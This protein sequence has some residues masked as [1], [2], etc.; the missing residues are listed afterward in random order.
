MPSTTP[1]D[2]PALRG[3][4]LRLAYHGTVVVE[5]AGLRLL[6]GEVTALIGPNGSGKSTVLRALA[7]LHKPEAGTVALPDVPDT[8]TLSASE[9]ARRVTLLSQSRPTPSGVCVRDV[10]GYGRH[11]HRGRWRQSDPD[12]PR[13]IAWAMDVTGTTAMAERPV[14]ELS[15]GELQRVWLA[16][17][18]AQDTRVLLLDEPTT[19]LD[20]RYQVE[21]LD[22][23][24]DLADDHGVAVGV[25][26]HDLDQA[27][28]VADHVVLLRRGEVVGAGLP[29]EVL[30]ADAL[31]ETYGI[32]IDVTVDEHGRVHTRPV[33]RHTRRTRTLAAV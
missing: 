23:V 5:R 14:D 8:R 19:Y 20:L 22:L 9:F 30:T 25:V 17:C 13:A 21:I 28:A 16:T 32:R 3:E 29:H 27:A 15:G 33:G 10:V 7:R 11:P 1:S 26:L 2:A 31:T 12:G 4:D 6:P 24:R 18:L